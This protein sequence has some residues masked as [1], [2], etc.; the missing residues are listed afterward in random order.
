MAL[1]LTPPFDELTAFHEAGHAVMA[2][3]CGR[4]VHKVSVR[5]NATRLGQCEFK[6][7]VQRPS[8]DWVET[9]I[10][11]ALAGAAAEELHAGTPDWHGAGR[12]LLAV[13]KLA[14]SRAGER[15]AERLSK[16]LYQKAL[17]LLGDE[18]AWAA[19]ARLAAELVRL[20]E[21][22]GRAATHFYA[23]AVRE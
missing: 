19:V 11:I 20:G 5:P 6:K 16:R 23:E 13:R 1:E 18:A 4:P 8:D 15:G 7:G 3:I 21:V 9:E 22:S 2:L 10:L 14:A 12:D 17:Y